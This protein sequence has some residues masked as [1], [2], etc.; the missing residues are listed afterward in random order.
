MVLIKRN[1][2]ITYINKCATH[3]Q[4]S[5]FPGCNKIT[6]QVG[7]CFR[8]S[9]GIV[10][11][12]IAI[13][14]RPQNKRLQPGIHN[15]NLIY[16]CATNGRAVYIESVR[17]VLSRDWAFNSHI[18]VISTCWNGVNAFRDAVLR[19]GFKNVKIT[20]RSPHFGNPVYII[21]MVVL[22]SILI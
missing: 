21:A 6:A 15:I 14:I 18:I 19:W 8:K 9:M 22:K 12:K 13:S 5:I 10:W 2:R 1:Y 16:K 7:Q 4:L 3:I 11:R 20:Y 17:K